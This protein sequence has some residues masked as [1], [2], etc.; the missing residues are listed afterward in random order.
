[1]G[2]KQKNEF[3]SLIPISKESKPKGSDKD[4]KAKKP[5]FKKGSWKH[6]LYK[7]AM[8]WKPSRF[9]EDFHF[10]KLENVLIAQSSD[11]EVMLF[12]KRVD[13]HTL[14]EIS[15]LA[16]D[17][18]ILINATSHMFMKI[19][20]ASYKKL[21][22]IDKIAINFTLQA[23]YDGECEI[24]DIYHFEQVIDSINELAKFINYHRQ[25]IEGVYEVQA[26]CCAYTDYFFKFKILVYKT[27][28]SCDTY[29]SDMNDFMKDYGLYEF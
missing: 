24:Q 3:Y 6:W 20:I 15:R 26:Q 17:C 28:G 4:K 21:M 25:G 11:P 2:A 29:K 7:L 9:V 5:H 1:M 10:T 12:K 16:D 13:K 23:S 19:S 18:Y 27:D 14:K 22:K 8:K